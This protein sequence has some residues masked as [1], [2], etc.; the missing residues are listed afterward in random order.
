METKCPTT[1]QWCTS[2]VSCQKVAHLF[3]FPNNLRIRVISFIISGPTVKLQNRFSVGLQKIPILTYEEKRSDRF[4]SQLARVRIFSD[5]LRSSPEFLVS[6]GWMRI[7]NCN[8]INKWSLFS[9]YIFKVNYWIL[10]FL[11][12][13]LPQNLLAPIVDSVHSTI[14]MSNLPGPEHRTFIEG[15]E[16]TNITFWV[17]NRGST[18]IGLSILSYGHKLQLGLMSDCVAIPTA[19]DAQCILEN[20]VKEIRYTAAIVRNNWMHWIVLILEI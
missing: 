17:P 8:V 1:W 10:S 2:L 7:L 13:L 14:S 5:R 4:F 19:T 3:F 12:C 20:M 16:L 9:W 6:K 11:T 15:H 18:G